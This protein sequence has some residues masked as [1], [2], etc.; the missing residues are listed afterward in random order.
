[1]RRRSRRGHHHGRTVATVGTVTKRGTLA[2]FAAKATFGA[3]TAFA[4]VTLL[5]LDRRAFDMGVDL[6]GQHAHHVVMQA[7]Q[8]FHF[9]HGRRR[10]HPISERHSGPCGSC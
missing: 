9:L 6:D 2:A 7:H 8:A 1:M 10:A 5:H 3:I 4:V